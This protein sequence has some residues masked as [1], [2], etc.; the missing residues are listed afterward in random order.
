MIHVLKCDPDTFEA[1]VCGIKTFEIR[2]DDRDFMIG[3]HLDL[4][5]T[6]FS[7]Q[8]MRERIK[9]LRF[10][11]RAAVV[12]VTHK[13]AGYGLQDGWCCL[14]HMPIDSATDRRVKSRTERIG[15][16]SLE[17]T[18]EVF[19]NGQLADALAAAYTSIG[20]LGTGDPRFQSS[21]EHYRALLAEQ[22]KRATA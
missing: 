22:L 7:G 9:P 21:V 18:F 4:R 6:E 5:E 11:G 20:P 12:I 8:E 1:T 17:Q 14:S 10:T 3:D 19:D 2:L 13:L 16:R 15:D